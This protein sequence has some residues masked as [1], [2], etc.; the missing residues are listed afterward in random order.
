MEVQGDLTQTEEEKGGSVTVEAEIGVMWL[1]ARGY[2][3][4]QKLEEARDRF[5]P[6]G[7]GGSP[8]L[9]TS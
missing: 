6:S 9:P 2:C 5:F 1:Q 8:A 4:H 7:Y 3:S